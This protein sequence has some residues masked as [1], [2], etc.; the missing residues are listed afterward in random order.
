V[1][2]EYEEY[3]LS[4]GDFDERVFLLDNAEVEIGTPR[5]INQSEFDREAISKRNFEEYFTS[6]V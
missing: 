2:F 1:S 6:K 5:K 4:S 3:V